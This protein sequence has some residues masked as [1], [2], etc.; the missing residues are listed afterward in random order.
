M[1]P[2]KTST[3]KAP[4]KAPAKKA[5]A[6]VSKPRAPRKGPKTIRNLRGTVVHARLLSQSQKDPFRIA[7][8]PR[9]KQ[10]DTTVI[11][12]VLQED[13]TYIQGIG[14]LWEIITETEARQIQYGPVGYLGRADAPEVIRPE[15]TTV[16][17][18]DDW[19]GTGRRIPQDR[20]VQ[21]KE[22]GSDMPAREFG[23]GMHTADVPGSDQALHA[24][25]SAA[26]KAAESMGQEA[27]PDGVDVSSRRVV[28]ERVKGQ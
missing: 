24:Q 5:P 7:L 4:A 9:G 12:V 17:T 20:N 14:V 1:A 22:R 23:T 15:D 6:A 28:I 8:N 18:A 13:A 21:R 26:Q 16:A 19:D 10:G 2:R 27:T 11:P 3:T 25:L